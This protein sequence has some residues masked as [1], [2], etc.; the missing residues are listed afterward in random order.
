MYNRNESLSVSGPMCDK[1][2]QNFD[3]QTLYK[4]SNYIL[5]LI[6]VVNIRFPQATYR[7][8]VPSTGELYCL[9]SVHTVMYTLNTKR[10]VKF[11]DTCELYYHKFRSPKPTESAILLYSTCT[12]KLQ[13]QAANKLPF[14]LCYINLC[15]Y[16]FNV[17]SKILNKNN[18]GH[19]KMSN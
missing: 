2:L 13:G 17:L 6:F 1:F 15:S 18:L 3:A 14:F 8:I 9:N 5:G 12:I 7:T 4:A 16:N 11:A 10:L 19:C